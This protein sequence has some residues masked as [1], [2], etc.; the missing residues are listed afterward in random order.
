[1]KL[2]NQCLAPGCTNPREL[3]IVCL[4]HMKERIHRIKMIEPSV[5]GLT[6][7]RSELEQK[8]AEYER[9]QKITQL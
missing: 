3:G 9:T 1:M 7:Y 6:S 5:S 2:I 8:V 4:T